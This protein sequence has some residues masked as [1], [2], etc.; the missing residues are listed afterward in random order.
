VFKMNETAQNN[1]ERAVKQ[2]TSAAF[3]SIFV[4]SIVVSIPGVLINEVVDAFSLSGT[5]EG[6]MGALTSLGFLLSMFFVVMI[7]GRFKKTVV[8]ASAFVVQSFAL[9]F[10]GFSPTFLLFCIFCTLIGFSGGFIDTFTNSSVVDLQTGDNTKSLGFLHGLFGVGSLLS[11]LLFV[12]LLQY[13]DWRGSHYMAAIASVLVAVLVF[14]LTNRSGKDLN[15]NVVREHLFTKADLLAYLRVKRNA[16]LAFSG[17]FAMFSIAAV[18]VWIVRYMTLQ[19]NAAEL[20]ALSITVYWICSTINRFLFVHFTKRAPMLFFSLGAVLSGI[21]VIVGVFSGNP[22][23]L[24]VM[25]GAF[26][27]CSGHFIPVLISECAAGYEGRTTFTTSFIMFVMCIARVIS[28]I[29]MAFTS[30]QVSLSAGM[31]IP[32]A[33]TLAA[34][35]CGWLSIKQGVNK[36]T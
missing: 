36:I 6:L 22:V 3:I 19:Y 31:M 17:F 2:I 26:G 15:E 23:I 10:C 18:L 1:N 30:T 33:A 16:A 29:I 34:A 27:L 11:P 12:W 35:G 32:V 4:Y 14:T 24:C 5:D 7:Q 21:C 9:F 28:P 8:L 13:T 25:M 20:G